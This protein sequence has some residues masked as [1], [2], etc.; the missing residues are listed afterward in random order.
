M[1]PLQREPRS[2]RVGL[3]V[4][5]VMIAVIVLG[6]LGMHVLVSPGS[7]AA[8]GSSMTMAS[9]ESGTAQHHEHQGSMT[10]SAI[11]PAEPS[12]PSVWTVVCVLALLLAAL[13][14]APSGSSWLLGRRELF[15]SAATVGVPVDGAPQHP[16]S[17]IVLSVSRT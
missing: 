6:L 12:H 2:T 5:A 1:P 3:G 4:H 8:H 15:W 11:T 7:H 10:E 17:L 13:F 16:P 9:V 14:V